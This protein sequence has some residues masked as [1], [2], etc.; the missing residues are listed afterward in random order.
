MS[1]L[2]R[3]M[4]ALAVVIAAGYGVYYLWTG[5]LPAHTLKVAASY[6]IL[7]VLTFVVTLITKPAGENH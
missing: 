1:G 4:L 6:A 3:I 5:T 7:V 2:L